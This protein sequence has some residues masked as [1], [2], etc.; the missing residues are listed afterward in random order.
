MRGEQPIPDI[1]KP[2][3]R[4]QGA[5]GDW[6]AVPVTPGD[7]QLALDRIKS[8]GRR[9]GR[10][11]VWAPTPPVEVPESAVGDHRRRQH[12]GRL[13]VL[14]GNEVVVLGTG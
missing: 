9:G 12:L 6:E 7:G 10:P 14:T 1:A 13:P 11:G 5:S 3:P 2:I 8:P 4:R